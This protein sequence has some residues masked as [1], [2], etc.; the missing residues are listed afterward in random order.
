M[1]LTRI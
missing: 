1:V